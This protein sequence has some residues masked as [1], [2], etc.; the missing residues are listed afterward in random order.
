MSLGQALYLI[1]S[2]RRMSRQGVG[3]PS[4]DPRATDEELKRELEGGE[5]APSWTP[6][7]LPD[8]PLPDL[9]TAFGGAPSARASADE[10]EEATP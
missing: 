1:A 10:A 8:L 2:A 9:S 7:P 5:P 3:C 4:I 6:P